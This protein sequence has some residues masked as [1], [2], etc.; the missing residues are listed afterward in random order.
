[1]L[2]MRKNTSNNFLIIFLL[3]FFSQINLKLATFNI[4][5]IRDQLIKLRLDDLGT[6]LARFLPGFECAYETEV[7]K[8]VKV[9]GGGVDEADDDHDGDVFKPIKSSK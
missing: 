1:M 5:H 6:V 9:Y 2:K 7:T 4:N 3:L 8:E